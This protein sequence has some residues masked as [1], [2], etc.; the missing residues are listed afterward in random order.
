MRPRKQVALLTSLCQPAIAG[1]WGDAE[2]TVAQ[3][4]VSSTGASRSLSPEDFSQ[5]I[6][7]LEVRRRPQQ[8]WDRNPGSRKS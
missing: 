5:L 3:A 7:G 1:R 8:Q 4:V 2:V 6:S